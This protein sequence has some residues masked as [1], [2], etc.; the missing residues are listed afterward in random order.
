MVAGYEEGVL[1]TTPESKNE[2]R[3]ARRIHHRIQRQGFNRFPHLAAVAAAARPVSIFASGGMLTP[4]LNCHGIFFAVRRFLPWRLTSWQ[5][6]TLNAP[7]VT[8]RTER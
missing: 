7:C 1:D 8:W 6:G 4:I 3:F 2:K 5:L